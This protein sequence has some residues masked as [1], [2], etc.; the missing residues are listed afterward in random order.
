V[1]LLVRDTCTI[2]SARALRPCAH[3]LMPFTAMAH[4]SFPRSVVNILVKFWII[5]LVLRYVAC[6]NALSPEGHALLRNPEDLSFR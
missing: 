2:E 3:A 6:I 5:R 1:D 4:T